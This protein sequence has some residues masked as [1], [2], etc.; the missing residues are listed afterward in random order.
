MEKGTEADISKELSLIKSEIDEIIPK[1]L[2][3]YQLHDPNK[4]FSS[5]ITLDNKVEFHIGGD[6]YRLS[7]I[8]IDRDEVEGYNDF[9]IDVDI[10]FYNNES[11]KREKLSQSIT[12][13]E[14]LL[15]IIEWIMIRL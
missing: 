14:T 1:V 11:K 15:D 4:L 12:G 13:F 9:C 10:D 8:Y 3:D 7:H 2:N 5:C 6:T